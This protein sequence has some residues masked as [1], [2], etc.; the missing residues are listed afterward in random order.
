M[1][2]HGLTIAIVAALGIG[3]AAQQAAPPVTL[4]PP[5]TKAEGTI[6]KN[7]APVSKEVLR[8]TLPKP[9]EAD[10][11]NGVHLLVL[12]DHRTPQINFS[13]IIDGAGGYYDPAPIPGLGGFVASLMREGTTTKTSEQILKVTAADVQRVA[14]KYLTKENRSVITTMPKAAAPKGNQQ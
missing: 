1:K 3:V 7:R 6:L 11:S 13:M 9:K 4:G 14:K 5:S 8:V 12:E 10:L 2:R